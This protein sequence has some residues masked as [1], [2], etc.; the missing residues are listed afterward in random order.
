MV[1]S[2][3]PKT[4]TEALEIL[5]REEVTIVAGGTD[6]MV[7]HRRWAQLQP[8]FKG[9]AL[10]ISGLE[11]LNYIDRQG[12]YV[13]IGAGVTL[14]EIMDHFHTPELLIDAI[15]L[16]ASP[17][18]RHTGTLAG[19]V[20]NASPAGDS[21]PVLYLLDASIV[22][23][24]MYGMRHVPIEEFIVGPGQ[25]TIN[26]DE[27]IKEIVLHDHSFNHVTYRKI[28]GRQADAISKVCFSAACTIKK[29]VI[30]DIRLAFGA[31]AP[32]IIRRKEMEQSMVGQTTGWLKEHRDMI[33]DQYMEFIQPIDDQRSTAAY[34]KQ[35]C[36]N[37][38]QEFLHLN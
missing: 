30:E 33:V 9:S 28:G 23:E 20:V 34:R 12:S 32:T 8:D 11:E 16:M 21:L 22:L 35:V 29:H 19:N 27:M 36:R 18:I 24:S 14:E 1:E 37:L 15:E 38:C 5:S 17:A 26:S 10:F 7:K 31:V 6:L 3:I 25:S 13:H 2:Y 4:Y